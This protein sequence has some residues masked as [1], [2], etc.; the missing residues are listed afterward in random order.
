ML[1]ELIS[2]KS[3][4]TH[5]FSALQ[6]RRA[7]R[8]KKKIFFCIYLDEQRKKCNLKTK[9]NGSIFCLHNFLSLHFAYYSHEQ[10]ECRTCN[11]H[12]KIAQAQK[13]P[14][15]REIQINCNYVKESLL[16]ESAN[17]NSPPLIVDRRRRP[18]ELVFE[19]VSVAHLHVNSRL[20]EEG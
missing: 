14:H 15:E 13:N 3:S 16:L 12:M 5:S 11:I 4:K 2:Q 18:S 19:C 7:G 17:K 9:I 10:V 8:T 1:H 20:F 6:K